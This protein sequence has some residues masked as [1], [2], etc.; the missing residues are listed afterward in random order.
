MDLTMKLKSFVF[1][2]LALFTST[3]SWG[4]FYDKSLS[5]ITQYQM[6]SGM[7]STD[8]VT[9]EWFETAFK[10]E[11]VFE[12]KEV[13]YRSPVYKGFS[14]DVTTLVSS[15]NDRDKLSAGLKWRGITIIHET[16]EAKASFINANTNS[17]LYVQ[18]GQSLPTVCSRS[19]YSCLEKIM[20]T[21]NEDIKLDYVA[22]K[23]QFAFA[24]NAGMQSVVGFNRYEMNSPIL[25]S[26]KID[27]NISST[28]YS[29]SNP[30]GT[31]TYQDQEVWGSTIDPYGKTTS[32]SFYYGIDGSEVRL[33]EAF[34]K[35]AGFH[36]GIIGSF[37]ILLNNY[38]VESSG[39]QEQLIND[40]YGTD[41]DKA[42]S[43]SSDL[44][45]SFEFNLGYMWVAN[46]SSGGAQIFAQTGVRGIWFMSDSL[47]EDAN[48]KNS[49][50]IDEFSGSDYNGWYFGIGANF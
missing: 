21:S 3:L 46:V 12:T 26:R 8:E 37:F 36:S 15:E 23:V 34:N 20:I 32:T 47:A 10:E 27:P 49:Y 25:L 42:D 45:L 19:K 16:G 11:I 50:V 1:F 24:W 9:D 22:D 17:D 14:I 31:Y 6:T 39:R 13:R 7:P 2:Y 4:D 33:Y 48:D 38:E 5:S 40:L 28:S 35:G 43:Y 29:P 44:I 30:L 18:A 41:F